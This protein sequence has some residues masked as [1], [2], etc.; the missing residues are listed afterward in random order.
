[1]RFTPKGLT[2]AF[3]ASEMFPGAC[4]K[5]QNL[6]FDQGNPELVVSRPGV[7]L[8]VD[9]GATLQ[10]ASPQFISVQIVVGSR[11]Y[12]MVATQRYP[13]HDEPFCW[14]TATNAVVPISG[15]TSL[16][17]PSSPAQFG[18]WTPPTMAVVG[19][20]II[21]T[22]PGF[23]GKGKH[24]W[25]DGTLWGSTAQ[26]GSNALWGDAY[27]FGIIDITNLAA[28]TWNATTTAINT[29]LAV[30]VA[31]ANFNN[32]AY[33]AVSNQLQYTD[34]LTNPPTITNAT[35]ALTI[36]D[37][38]A[39]N[40]L[41]GLPAQT[42]G[43]G[44]VQA[45]TVFKVN[46]TWQILGDPATWT[47]G[48][49]YISLT[50]GTNA[51]RSVVQCPNGLYFTSSGGPYFIDLLGTL[52]PLS[53]SLQTQQPDIEVPFEN[54]LFPTRAAA[55]YNST[56]YR[57]CVQTIVRGQ[58]GI[59][60]YWFD[61]HRRR[62]NGPHTFPYDCASVLGDNFI[63]SG[64]LYP[65][66]LMVSPTQQN[67]AFVNTDLNTVMTCLLLSSTFPKTN[68]MLMKQVSES[69]IELSA[70]SGNI[71]YFIEAQDDQGNDLGDAQIAVINQGEPWGGFNW[72]D[73]TV[74]A[75]SN[76]WGGG[77]LWGGNAA[78]WGDGTLWGQQNPKVYWAQAAG[79]GVLWGK[80]VQN[81]PH[82]Y[83]VP[84]PAPLVF[85]KMQLQITATA[86]AE[87]GIGTFYARYQ[88]TGY[89]TLG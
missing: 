71:T 86:S 56:L 53:Y 42:V 31:V 60:D 67:Q 88:K 43:S 78:N 50:T 40:A 75:T 36:G 3:D 8:L 29:L 74:W 58:Q 21:V 65:G 69:Q 20:M 15:V 84:W 33:F 57:I 89:M 63:L 25:G 77:S 46:Q 34:V 51:P 85:E 76:L 11:V 61:E 13:G 64:A 41:S 10:F 6:V 9:L 45:L 7:T 26:S 19:T 47:L 81:V 39:V 14:D 70:S 68:D 54:A 2:D 83:P 87:V 82:T 30:P 62:W 48:Q 73:G 49:N 55:G 79:S 52:R 32:R 38:G 44:L 12:G 80:G 17:T 5:L 27:T 35:Q 37:S 16:N 72:G 18:D 22:H 23:S 1:M 4:Q 24:L 28:P 59:N 66:K